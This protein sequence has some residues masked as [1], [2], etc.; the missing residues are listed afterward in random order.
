MRIT[1]SRAAEKTGKILEKPP[2]K[3]LGG[4][5]RSKLKILS[6]RINPS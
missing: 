2:K 4:F 6:G 1:G 3:L 5:S